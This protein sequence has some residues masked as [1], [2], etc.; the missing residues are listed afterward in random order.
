M[1]SRP[2]F[3]LLGLSW[4]DA[5]LLKLHGMLF[6]FMA[7]IWTKFHPFSPLHGH[8]VVIASAGLR[9]CSDDTAYLQT[10]AA[11]AEDVGNHGKSSEDQ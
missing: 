2:C 1:A 7:P 3:L 8:V 4:I 5:V 10:K 6:T 9:F 11:P